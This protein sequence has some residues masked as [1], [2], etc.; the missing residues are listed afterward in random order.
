MKK[1]T[2]AKKKVKKMTEKKLFRQGDVLLI[3]GGKATKEHK[4]VERIKGSVVLAFGEKTGHHHRFTDP[5]VCMLQREGISDRVLT[6]DVEALLKHEEHAEIS[7][8]AGTYSVRIQCEWSEGLVR[9][10]ED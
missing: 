7:V 4:P 9:R 2:P 6:V 1:R 3:P 10:V 5:G 8:P